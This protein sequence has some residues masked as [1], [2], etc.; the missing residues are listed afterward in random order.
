MRKLVIFCFATLLLSGHLIAK[1]KII[2][3]CNQEQ[4]D[5]ITD[6]INDAVAQSFNSIIVKV[7]S[8]TYYFKERHLSLSKIK[9]NT[10]SIS[11]VGNNSLIVPRGR[12]INS[13]SVLKDYDYNSSV[14]DIG[15][16]K[17]INVWSDM[18]YADEKVEVLDEATKLCCLKCSK[19]DCSNS[20][21]DNAYI[22]IT[23]WCR[24]F[25][26]KIL[27]IEDSYVYFIAE[28]LGPGIPRSGR[29][30]FNVNNDYLYAYAIPRYRVC[31]LKPLNIGNVYICETQSFLWA[32]STQC[33][34]FEIKGFTFLGNNTMG[35]LE[36]T[37]C[38]YMVFYDCK[39]E[40]ITVRNCRFIGQNSRVIALSK[41]DNVYVL[42]NR[43]LNTFRNGITA[44]NSCRNTI[45][46]NNVF[47][48]NGENLS[49]NRCV[50]CS[51]SNYYIANNS[52]K[53]YGYCG[54]SVGLYYTAKAENPPCGIVE[55]NELCYSEDRMKELWRY[56]IMDSGSIY[57]WTQNDKSVI[58]FNRIDNYGGVSFNNGIYCDDGTKG[59]SIYGNIITGIVNG[60][61]IHLRRFSKADPYV[62]GA[63]VSNNIYHNVMDGA[64][65]FEGNESN[66]NCSKGA[67]IF[68]VKEEGI[69]L[70]RVVR[71]ITVIEEDVFISDLGRRNKKNILLRHSD[72][73]FI[74][75]TIRDKFCNDFFVKQ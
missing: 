19:L 38:S 25:Y 70:E 8:G 54:I 18:E 56:S 40:S 4:F 39:A 45:I 2:R 20:N 31:N 41:T 21:V 6:S 30:E 24:T 75:R 42:N 1:E 58:R 33:K 10:V 65:V 48:E 35:D 69:L 16:Q 22:M 66:S 29:S 52:F 9:S 49:N 57:T 28:N 27:R 64:F 74:K 44:F 72:L 47:E 60:S 23:A 59:V 71:N 63:N 15:V 67:N 36:S 12:E 46:K 26:Y 68:L 17:R 3:V 7:A 14:I 55:H 37:A 53:D 50:S 43:F 62:G 5:R 51:G 34:S 61:S 11:I 13:N 32:V 73:K